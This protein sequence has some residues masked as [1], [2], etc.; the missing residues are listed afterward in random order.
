M[1]SFFSCLDC[2]SERNDPIKYP[3]GAYNYLEHHL[4]R[5][6]FISEVSPRA[7]KKYGVSEKSPPKKLPASAMEDTINVGTPFTGND[8]EN[9]KIEKIEKNEKSIVFKA[10]DYV[11]GAVFSDNRPKGVGYSSYAQKGWDI[12][13]VLCR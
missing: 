9:E 2:H 6:A 11:K 13:V 8:D 7:I 10:F 4:L 1:K 3:D 5:L 12:K